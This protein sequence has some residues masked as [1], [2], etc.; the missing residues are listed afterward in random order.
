[1]SNWSDFT[2]KKLTR[3]FDEKWGD[4]KA[5]N[6]QG[7]R[8]IN[9]QYID[10]ALFFICFVLLAGFAFQASLY[11]EGFLGLLAALFTPFLLGEEL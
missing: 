7:D 3:I 4:M 5:Y 1:M 11:I 10:K 8:I 2:T 6:P 9:L